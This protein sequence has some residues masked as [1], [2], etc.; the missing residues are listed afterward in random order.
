MQKNHTSNLVAMIIGLI[1]IISIGG[2]A[3]FRLNK[4]Q[5]TAKEISEASKDTP[6]KNMQN[7]TKISTSDLA[8]KILAHPENLSLIDVRDAADFSKEHL[9]DSQNIPLS[10]IVDAMS[11]LDKNNDY[12]IID[13]DSSIESLAL[14]VEA[15]TNIGFKNISYLDGGFTAWKLDFNSTISAGDPD[16]FVDQ[17]KIKYI[18]TDKLKEMLETEDNLIILDVRKKNQFNEGH[19]KGAT[20]IYLEDLEKRRTEIPFNKKIIL[21][22]NDGLWAFKAGVRLFDMGL[23]NAL[24]LSD[25]LDNWKKKGFELIKGS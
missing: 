11:P 23:F 10:V 9:L 2:L 6:I 4:S 13:Y 20:N 1:L 3:F 12:I 25:G 24:I 5:N 22:D 8:K 21:Y 15:L 18:Q 19:I 16:S 17:S 14:I 7:A